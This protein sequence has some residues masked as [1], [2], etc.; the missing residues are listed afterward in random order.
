MK[1]KTAGTLYPPVS[2]K[3]ALSNIERHDWAKEARDRIVEQA[4]PWLDMSD[5][6]LWGLMFGNTIR[7]SWMVWSNGHCPSCNE[8]VPMYNWKMNALKEPWKVRCPH[9]NE[10]FPKNDFHKFYVSGL[11]EYGVFEP[12]KADRSLLFNAEHPEPEDPLHTFGVDDGDGYSDGN[13]RW[14]FIGAYLVY[15]QWKQA[16]VG[17]IKKLAAAY[18]VTGNR[19]YARK[20]AI[21]LDRVAD[22]YPTFDFA[23]EALV[24]ER[25]GSNGYV[26]MWHDA[27]EETREMAIAYDQVF[28]ALK[29]DKDLVGFLAAR[30]K[31]F[32]LENPKT[33]FADVQRNI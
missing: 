8:S 12:K 24:Y 7:R 1:K 10:A 6:D 15:G 22:L 33:S 19:A 30:A 4:Q 17:G 21:L 25:G 14:R 9:C 32:G 2:I 31:E 26:S 29:T 16:V 13:K 5:D 11:D 27:C 23:R 3:Q 28:E 20:T 18:V